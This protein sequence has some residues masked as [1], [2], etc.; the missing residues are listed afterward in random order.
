[1]GVRPENAEPAGIGDCRDDVT[2]VTEREE[3]ELDA[4]LFT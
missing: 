2:A 4:E 1:V 3:R